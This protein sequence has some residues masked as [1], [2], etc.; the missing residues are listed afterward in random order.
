MIVVVGGMKRSGSTWLYNVARVAMRH[1]GIEPKVGE[2]DLFAQGAQPPL[3]IKQH[4]WKPDLAEAADVVLSSVRD[5]EGVYES[6]KAFWGREP[7]ARELAKIVAHWQRWSEVANYEMPYEDLLGDPLSVAQWV[8]AV[9]GLD[10]DPVAVLDEVN[11][12]ELPAEG[13]DPVTF[14]FANHRR[15]RS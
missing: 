7:T 1:A 11:R 5:V 8:V 14:Y 6:L 10:A 13:K 15:A 4:W 3:L 9:L 12:I 2:Y